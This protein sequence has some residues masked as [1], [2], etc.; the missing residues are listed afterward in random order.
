VALTIIIIR[1]KIF[2]DMWQV[3]HETI[4]KPDTKKMNKK[5]KKYL[6]FEQNKI[7]DKKHCHTKNKKQNSGF[8]FAGYSHGKYKQNEVFLWWISM[9]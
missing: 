3:W 1:D 8:F 6:K 2:V 5:K 4:I 7:D 9:Q